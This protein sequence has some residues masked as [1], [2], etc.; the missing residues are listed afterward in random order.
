MKRNRIILLGGAG[1]LVLLT[2]GLAFGGPKDDADAFTWDTLARGEIRETLTASGEIRA[3]TQ[4]NVGSVVVGEIKERYVE[5]GQAVKKGQPLV[6]IDAIQAQQQM[7][8]GAAALE[9]A[10]RDADRL[11]AAKARSA[12]TFQRSERL[13]G[14]GLVSDE[15]FR[16]ARLAKESALLSAASAR[17]GV[18]QAEASYRGLADALSKTTLRAPMD[19]VVTGLKAEKGETAIPGTSNL[20]GAVLMVI[21]DMS[22]VM[23]QIKVNESEVVRLRKGQTAQVAVEPL[24]GR[25][26]HGKV[27]EVATSAEKS[28]QDANLYLVKVFLDMSTQ[29]VGRLRPGMSARAVVL[30]SEAKDVLRVPL[31]AVL[32]REGSAEEAQAK[33]LLAPAS[34]SVVMVARGGKALETPVTL[35]IANTGWFEVK[36]GLKEGD[37]VLTGP[38]RKLKELKDKASAALRAKSDGQLE[39]ERRRKK[40]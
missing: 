28:G 19:G 32:E 7:E 3:R 33:G 13:Y 5:D 30:T 14:Q 26:F 6:R 16:G 1:F 40:K 4:I 35:G 17:A 18:A 12:E 25:V 39:E 20:P 10:R 27:E 29:E 23:A 36:E 11:E 21:S 8:R 2:L 31:Q 37:K 15:E 38:S 9:A 24:P 22:Q 34:R